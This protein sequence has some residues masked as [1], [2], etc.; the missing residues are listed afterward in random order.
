MDQIV[1][2]KAGQQD[3]RFFGFRTG[4]DDDTKFAFTWP[5]WLCLHPVAAINQQIRW[6]IRQVGRIDI[7]QRHLACAKPA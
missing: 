1:C 3:G 4:L 2:Q 5:H 7:D 6:N